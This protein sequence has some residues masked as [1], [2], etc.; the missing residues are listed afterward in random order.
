MRRR[1]RIEQHLEEDLADSL[2]GVEIGLAVREEVERAVKTHALLPGI[3]L[4]E[5]EAR[6]D[7]LCLNTLY[8]LA[9]DALSGELGDHQH[10]AQARGGGIELGHSDAA[11][12]GG[13]GIWGIGEGEKVDG[14]M[15]QI[16]QIVA[17]DALFGELFFLPKVFSAQGN[18]LL[19]QCTLSNQ[20]CTCK[21]R[22]IKI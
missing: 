6:S 16:V 4:E 18:M 2:L 13:G 20:F 21:A 12:G 15:V 7:G 9:P 10:L 11:R 1:R 17:V 19:I 22:N 3:D 8:Q 5:G 14:A